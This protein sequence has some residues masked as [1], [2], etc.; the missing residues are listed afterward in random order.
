MAYSFEPDFTY[1]TE[2]GLPELSVTDASGNSVLPN[3]E[4]AKARAVKTDYALGAQSPG[5][6]D[7][8][9]QT[10]TGGEQQ[11]RSALAAQEDQKLNQ[12]RL[13]IMQGIAQQKGNN[14][15]PADVELVKSISNV[16]LKTDPKTV[17]ER[18]FAEKYIDDVTA[19]G[20]YEADI[21]EEKKQAERDIATNVASDVEVFKTKRDEWEARWQQT[22]WMPTI[23]YY[24]WS[25]VPTTSWWYQSQALEKKPGIPGLIGNNMR[26]NV[27]YM[28]SLSMPE[29]TAQYDKAMEY[30]WSKNPLDAMAF[31]HAMVSFGTSE[32]YLGNVF[33]IAMV[34][35]GFGAQ[36]AKSVIGKLIRRGAKDV[37]EHG[38][39]REA[40]A[41]T[42][43]PDNPFPRPIPTEYYKDA[44][45]IRR[46]TAPNNEVQ[47]DLFGQ[48]PDQGSFRFMN[49]PESTAPNQA[50]KLPP[51]K[52]RSQH[53]TE[54][55]QY[56][57]QGDL[58]SLAKPEERM[59]PT[60][61]RFGHN[62]G[63]EKQLPPRAM[64]R[65]DTTEAV[66]GEFPF[67]SKQDSF[68]L[69][70]GLPTKRP[71][72]EPPT[73]PPP[74]GGTGTPAP[75]Q[76]VK[77]QMKDAVKALEE[78]HFDA[79]SVLA[80]N[81]KIAEAG[82]VG[83]LRRM[84]TTITGGLED[85]A[86]EIPTFANP[87][88]FLRD[89]K[90]MSRE[91][92]RR[93]SESAQGQ[94]EA[95]VGALMRSVRGSRLTAEGLAAGKAFTQAILEREYLTRPR[96]SDSLVN[97]SHV[98]AEAHPANVDTMV[99]RLGN[100]TAEPFTSRE[101]A[102]LYR[103]DVFKLGDKEATIVQ[104]GDKYWLDIAKHVDETVDPVRAVWH[105]DKPVLSGMVT[106]LTNRL[107]DT[108]DRFTGGNF[109][110][111]ADIVTA[112]SRSQRNVATTGPQE[113]RKEIRDTIRNNIEKPLNK[114]E[115]RELNDVLKEN[116]D[117]PSK[118]FPGERGEWYNTAGEF[119]A[120]FQRLHHK[121]P[122][123]AQINAYDTFKRLSDFDWML[124]NLAVYRDKARQGV[125]TWRYHFTVDES[126]Q[127]TPWFEGKFHEK[128]PWTLGKKG[129]QN[130]GLWVWNSDTQ[131][132]KFYYTHR[133]T[134]DE[135]KYIDGLITENGYKVVQVFDPKKHPLESFAKTAA[136]EDLKEQVNYVI[137]NAF[138]RS[139]LEWKQVDYRPGGHVIYPHRWYVAQPIISSGRLG[140]TTYFGDNVA[141]NVQTERE[142][143]MWAERLDKAR[144]LMKAG[145]T[146][147][148]HA[149]R[150]ANLPF[151]KEEFEN[152]FF[153]S[154]SPF[155]LDHRIS[156][157]EAG[158]NTMETNPELKRLGE[159]GE[160]VDSTRNV[161][162]L[163]NFMDKA[164]L[165]DRDLVLKTVSDKTKRLVDA[166]QLDPFEALNRA[167]GQSLR[168]L[169]MNDYKIAA[170]EEWI[171][172]FKGVLR[173]PEDVLSA[174]PQ[175]FLHNPQWENV[176]SN[177]Y[178][179]LA[180]AKAVQK[181]IVNFTGTQ[182]ELGSAINAYKTKLLNG[183]YDVGGQ[184]AA[185]WVEEKLFAITD[186]VA[187][188]RGV[189]FHSKLGLF[190]PVQLFL[191]MQSI[192]HSVAVAGPVNGFS[193]FTGALGMR[194][195]AHNPDHLETVAKVI[196]WKPAEF[197][198]LY[199]NMRKSGIFQVAG[200]AALRDDVFDPKLF[201]STAGWLLDSGTFFFNEG[202]R[203]TRMTAFATAFR[204][205]KQAGIK[206][207]GNRELADIMTRADLLSVNMT[208]ASNAGWQ[209]GAMSVPTQFFAF[210]ARLAEQMLGT[211]LTGVEKLRAL[212][213]YSALYGIPI[214]VGTTVGVWP[215]YDSVKE[216]ALRR[217][218]DMSPKYLELMQ[219]GILS[220]AFHYLTGHEYNV[221][222]RYG[223]G[224]N[225]EL[226]DLLRGEK[227]LLDV[228][229]GAS[230][231]IL[232][233]I[234]GAAWPFWKAGADVFNGSNN[235]P[236]MASDWMNLARN[237]ST[238]DN[239][240]KS[241]AVLNYGKWITKTG[242]EVGQADGMDAFM[243][244]VFGLSP[245][246]VAETYLWQDALKVQKDG[247]KAY[248]KSAFD[249]FRRG[250][251]AAANGDYKAQADFFQRART[252]MAAGDFNYAD[253]AR[254][255]QNS[256]KGVGDLD[257]K[258]NWDAVRK[259]P[260]S[261]FNSRFERFK[262]MLS[263]K[264]L[265][266]Q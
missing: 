96:F 97:I 261:V 141:L 105:P 209:T 134:P 155:S 122:T 166:E 32:Q 191:Q 85:L 227:K 199:E 266:K 237:V 58:F 107:M 217:G 103:K 177:Q 197:R 181:A 104:E 185:H 226:R 56:G 234:I 260:D 207:I 221:A 72:A 184:G 29:R 26:S 64:P 218:I 94:T 95:L 187:F 189:A 74:S 236:L 98:P 165:Q 53:S 169:W 156:F 249:N 202:E 255:F 79:E 124:R 254:I 192:A 43:Q 68:N 140:K 16:E 11:L 14:F 248:E 17:L 99:L 45:P 151:T 213:T 126:K 216:E 171:Q 90:V 75:V 119:E 194:W 182:T 8:T 222:Q 245:Q 258:V 168:N 55:E 70:S 190:N 164:F 5:V 252:D 111:S 31:A 84:F 174:F 77:V 87:L 167:M 7:L 21:H 19:F 63:R 146:D 6:P 131:S 116:R 106:N 62:K 157:K 130:A 4:A 120:A 183:V 65:G 214:G 123:E 66:Q 59:S 240:A 15:G 93:V 259:S 38:V 142:A 41:V 37:V 150:E 113:L 22:G 206:N 143:S 121:P 263:N 83:A 210:N 160:L 188:M 67:V 51:G 9:S 81:G 208:R 246:H 82:T 101:Q 203:L 80:A 132:G 125:E 232:G 200:E 30:L 238:L 129:D 239:A 117:M 256:I 2:D 102:A 235:Y 48:Q 54:F 20:R 145:R 186:P 211:R 158:K 178:H 36:A 176:A 137:S 147:E 34:G 115:R 10:L 92:A 198:E 262:E 219:E 251:Q 229:F 89:S 265:G 78:P 25:M 114:S 148:A 18:K 233:D 205:A 149:F 196:G 179:E 71:P 91:Y 112:F 220:T 224:N 264:N 250:M 49:G 12:T 136:G 193:G 33:E 231:T 175:Y 163:S 3:P 161:H 244:A 247:Q 173:P 50:S 180:T 195:V 52:L 35:T 24:V 100:T 110:S 242:T 73:T 225:K 144:L 27:M 118:S 60:D 46:Q 44:S 230:G 223:P 76:Q 152:L 40:A 47:L 108:V 39:E 212:S 154:D 13:Q 201:R 28:W 135:K 170:I 241:L 139:P 69:E 162:D 42:T 127:M 61:L 23:G 109:R 153:R 1:D 215:F 57:S 159:R 243:V 172:N 128:M 86:R 133:L 88:G 228:A 138:E 253:R 204:E 257:A